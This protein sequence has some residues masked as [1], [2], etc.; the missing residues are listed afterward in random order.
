MV[1]HHFVRDGVFCGLRYWKFLDYDGHLAAQ[2]GF[3]GL[4]TRRTIYFVERT[5]AVGPFHRR[6]TGR[7][8]FRRP[9]LTDFR[10][11]GAQFDGFPLS[12]H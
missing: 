12:A 2:C 9:L 7:R 5:R 8:Y 1:T 3:L 6:R 11:D 10:Y 4:Y